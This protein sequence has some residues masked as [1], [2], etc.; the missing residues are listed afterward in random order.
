MQRIHEGPEGPRSPKPLV[1]ITN[2]WAQNH[3]SSLINVYRGPTR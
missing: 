1:V 3:L 2:R